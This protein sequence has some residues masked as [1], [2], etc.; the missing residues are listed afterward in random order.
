MKNKFRRITAALSSAVIAA[1]VSAPALMTGGMSANAASKYMLEYLDRGICAVNTGSGMLVSWRYLA[2]DDDNATYKLY[3]DGTLIYTSE[4]GKST[5]Y[6]DTSGSA[7]S[8]Y[9][10]DT[11][12]GTK[13]TGSE[14]VQTDI[15]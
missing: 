13:I 7:K 12:S 2:N 5:C 14:D 11:L 8:T 6:L 3:R 10:V 15:K 1:S 9:R 4:A